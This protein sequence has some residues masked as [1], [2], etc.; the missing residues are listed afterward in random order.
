MSGDGGGVR[1]VLVYDLNQDWA[2][3]YGKSDFEDELVL[4][5]GADRGSTTRFFLAQ[6][7]RAVVCSEPPSSV[8]YRELE[9]LAALDDRIALARPVLSARDAAGL[10]AAWRPD[11]VKLDCEGCEEHFIGALGDHPPPC[12]LAETHDDSIRARLHDALSTDY[13][14]T[15]ISERESRHARFA[16]I[17]ADR[18]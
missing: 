17:R 11:T 18:R 2:A 3:V 8:Y 14:V 15:V 4:D 5:V 1:R 13:A 7:A 10:L 9:A 6:G 12:V 16:V